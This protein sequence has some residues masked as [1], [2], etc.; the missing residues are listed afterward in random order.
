MKRFLAALALL[1][2]ISLG[3]ILWLSSNKVEPDYSDLDLE[4]PAVSESENSFP[5]L[6]EAAELISLTEEESELV[7]SSL[8]GDWH[9][10]QTI[11]EILNRNASA[12]ERFDEAFKR[13]FLGLP[14]IQSL[15]EEVPYLKYWK[16]LSQLKALQARQRFLSG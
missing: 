10:E 13:P 6:E 4:R 16:R 7:S 11:R 5:L 2:I 9:D 14:E 12:L 8:K 3:I 1:I 15:G